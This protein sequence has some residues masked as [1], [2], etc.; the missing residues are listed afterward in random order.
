MVRADGNEHAECML[1]QRAVRACSLLLLLPCSLLHAVVLCSSALCSARFS[2][3]CCA[4]VAR[5]A[6]CSLRLLCG[7]SVAALWLLCCCSGHVVCIF[8][9]DTRAS[10]RKVKLTRDA[11]G[12]GGSNHVH[13]L[14]AVAPL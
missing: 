13:L 14:T 11:R 3:I 8:L 12:A 1:E 10:A 6:L 7:C 4:H 9:R 5:A 2:T